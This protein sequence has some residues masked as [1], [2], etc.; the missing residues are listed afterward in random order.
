MLLLCIIAKTMFY[1][2]HSIHANK[3]LHLRCD[4]SSRFSSRSRF[5]L[6][7][8]VFIQ[9]RDF[10][11]LLTSG[12]FSL[13]H[14]IMKEDVVCGLWCGLDN[15]ILIETT[16]QKK[17]K[18][19]NILVVVYETVGSGTLIY[20]CLVVSL[21]FI[22]VHRVVVAAIGCLLLCF[23]SPSLSCRSFLLVFPSQH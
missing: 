11:P 23:H 8:D 19:T 1:S 10:C 6:L 15:H 4:L 20:Y 21:S 12:P 14:A 9:C 17:G 22:D 16:T 18:H 7:L 3:L 13:S 5:F 2:T